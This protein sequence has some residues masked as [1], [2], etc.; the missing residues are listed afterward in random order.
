MRNLFRTGMAAALVLGVGAGAALAQN[1]VG[2]PYAPMAPTITGPLG[3]VGFN[4]FQT[5]AIAARNDWDRLS[6]AQKIELG[7]RC[8]FVVS[9]MTAAT[10]AIAYC[11]EIGNVQFRTTA[12]VPDDTV[13]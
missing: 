1:A 9:D 8:R 4:S 11:R 5:A 13:E 10:D 6:D 7:D 2:G 12:D 3:G